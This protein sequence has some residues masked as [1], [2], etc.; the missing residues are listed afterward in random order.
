MHHIILIVV[1]IHKHF[2]V[3]SM[4]AFPQPEDVTAPKLHW[5]LIKVL[6]NGGPE[7]YSVAVGKWDNEPCLAIRW[8]ACEWRPVGNPQSRGLPTW[9]ILPFCHVS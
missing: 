9:F 4:N 7:E 1:T 6:Y 5:S 3:E 8:N 2:H